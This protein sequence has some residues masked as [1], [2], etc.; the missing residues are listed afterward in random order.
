MWSVLIIRSVNIFSKFEI[1]LFVPLGLFQHS[2]T[3]S[4]ILIGVFVFFVDFWF[5]TF[6]SFSGLIDFIIFLITSY[7]LSFLICLMLD[8]SRTGNGS[9][10]LPLVA[11]YTYKRKPKAVGVFC[12]PHPT[13][14][15]P[16]SCSKKAQS[17]SPRDFSRGPMTPRRN[18]WPPATS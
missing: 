6:N 2:L 11:F 10:T 15:P 4:D 5:C 16:L 9:L 7:W 12:N 14:T 1:L 3:K 17:G 8:I 18:V 13:G